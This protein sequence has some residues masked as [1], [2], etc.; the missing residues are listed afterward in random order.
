MQA[1][2]EDEDVRGLEGAA[3]AHEPPKNSPEDEELGH[4]VTRREAERLAFAGVIADERGELT[5]AA[6]TFRPGM[7]QVLCELGDEGRHVPE[8]ADAAEPGE[9]RNH[10]V[11]KSFCDHGEREFPCFGADFVGEVGEGF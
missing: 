11:P 8:L 10:V 5:A 2:L 6:E 9:G 4:D 3:L 1:L 7:V